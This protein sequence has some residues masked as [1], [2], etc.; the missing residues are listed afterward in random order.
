L[1][2]LNGSTRRSDGRLYHITWSLD[3]SKGK[4]PFHTNDIIHKAELLKAKIPIEV[5]GKTFTQSTAALV[6]KK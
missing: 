2:E 5:V 4:K 1:V 3:R 6:N